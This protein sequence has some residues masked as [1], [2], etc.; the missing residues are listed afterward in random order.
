LDQVAALGPQRNVTLG[1][2]GGTDFCIGWQHSM[3]ASEVYESTRK[4]LALWAS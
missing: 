3:R 4:I 1:T 2:Q